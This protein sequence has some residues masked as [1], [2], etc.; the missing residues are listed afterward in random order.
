[1]KESSI[2]PSRSLLRSATVRHETRYHV[3]N[4]IKLHVHHF[5]DPSVKPSGLTLLL[6]HGFMDAGGT[7]DLVA[8]SLCRAG[9]ALVSPDLRGFGQSDWVSA[10]GYY[11]FP[12]YV[13]DVD[14]LVCALSPTRLGVVGHSMGGTVSALYTGARPER[15][16]RLALLEG[17]GPPAHAPELAVDRMR[18]WLRQLREMSRAQ[19]PMASMDDALSRLRA[20]H[21]K[22]KR[23]VL[24]T[25]AR[26]LIRK[27]EDGQL[28]WAYDPLHRTTAPTPF[29]E[30][31]FKAFLQN[32]TCPTL[33]VSGGPDG[34]HP[35]GEAERVATLRD[36]ERFEIPDAGHM[37]HWTAPEALGERLVGF[38]GAPLRA[39]E[40]GA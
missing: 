39:E 1:V 8:P 30:A 3:V 33:W 7:W 12:D 11:H 36:V 26:W 28:V 10:G 40:P 29:Y 21:P 15:V 6:L 20:A 14:A 22:V 37:M 23:E 9:H 24:E 5:D 32:I 27:G 2:D 13:A 4:G 17:M 25:R 16:E 35:D 31:S 18:S 34:W 19:R 38:F